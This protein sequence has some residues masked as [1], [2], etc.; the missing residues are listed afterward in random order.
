M[1]YMARISR[2]NYV[3][4]A[5]HILTNEISKKNITTIAHVSRTICL[6]QRFTCSLRVFVVFVV[7]FFVYNFNQSL[8]LIYKVIY[9]STFHAKTL[10]FLNF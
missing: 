9:L 3:M 1:A 10:S 7:L 5:R 2:Y 4:V 6:L 8:N